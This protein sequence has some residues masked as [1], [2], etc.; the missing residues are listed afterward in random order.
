MYVTVYCVGSHGTLLVKLIFYRMLSCTVKAVYIIKPP[1]SE[2][3]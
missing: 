1:H 3:L 2:Q